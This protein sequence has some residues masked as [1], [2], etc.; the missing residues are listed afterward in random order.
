MVKDANMEKVVTNG[1]NKVY[2]AS[3]NVS[4]LK[5]VLTQ[6]GW[7]ILRN[8][9]TGIVIGRQRTAKL[10]Y[11]GSD[12]KCYLLPDYVFIHEDYVGNSFINTGAV[13]NGLDGEE[14]L[15]ENVK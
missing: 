2:G 4:A 10:A 8:S 12:G 5:A 3:R 15:C 14:M 1:F 9:L 11:K 6:N 7:T 13:F